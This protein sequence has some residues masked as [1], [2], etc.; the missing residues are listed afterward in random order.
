MKKSLDK[1][2]ST[3][4][5]GQGMPKTLVRTYGGPYRSPAKGDCFQQ[6]LSLSL[7]SEVLLFLSVEPIPVGSLLIVELYLPENIVSA[8]HI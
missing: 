1:G 4:F 8:K 5:H 6:D 2:D 7:T 3:P